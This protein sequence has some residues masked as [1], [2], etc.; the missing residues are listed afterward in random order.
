MVTAKLPSRKLLLNP[1][2]LQQEFERID[3]GNMESEDQN[4]ILLCCKQCNQAK[5]SEHNTVNRK[6]YYSP[7]NREPKPPF[8][9]NLSH[10]APPAASIA[11][12]RF[13]TIHVVSDKK[14]VVI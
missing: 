3:R 8:V 7:L 10:G 11:H 1:K 12:L 6:S 5:K 13:N 14:Q 9:R 4:G 2:R